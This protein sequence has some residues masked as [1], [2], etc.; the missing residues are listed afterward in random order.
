MPTALNFVIGHVGINFSRLLIGLGILVIAAEIYLGIAK[1][2]QDVFP[3]EFTQ[4]VATFADT[5]WR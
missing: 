1:N 2:K 4:V 3:T 5:G